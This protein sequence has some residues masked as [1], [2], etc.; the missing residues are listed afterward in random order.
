M[1][2][3]MFSF[4]TSSSPS[5]NHLYP[6]H[7]RFPLATC[8]TLHAYAIPSY[9][10]F[11]SDGPFLA[12]AL[13]YVLR[14]VEPFFFWIFFCWQWK[15]ALSLIS[16]FLHVWEGKISPF[17]VLFLIFILSLSTFCRFMAIHLPPP[18]G[19]L[20]LFLY[21]YV[22]NYTLPSISLFSCCF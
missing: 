22:F 2:F 3:W 4:S 13:L 21:G 1:S 8:F 17:S 12:V 11:G 9:L 10:L 15:D 16:L 14:F 5:C 7:L 19:C 18:R 6:I 20:S